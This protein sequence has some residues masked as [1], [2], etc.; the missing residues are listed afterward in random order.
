[1]LRELATMACD[2]QGY[3]RGI[4]PLTHDPVM[5]VKPID[6]KNGTAADQQSLGTHLINRKVTATPRRHKRMDFM[7][8]PILPSSVK[9]II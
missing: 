4:A 9:S 5:G 7:Y 6:V 8:D 3:H 1:M 2:K